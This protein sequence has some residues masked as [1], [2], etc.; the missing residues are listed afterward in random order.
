MIYDSLK[1]ACSLIL[2]DRLVLININLPLEFLETILLAGGETMILWW[3]I[4]LYVEGL[5]VAWT[6][7]DLVYRSLFR[8]YYQKHENWDLDNTF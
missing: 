5:H 3:I 8:A 4:S 6:R 1:Y 7:A 2:W